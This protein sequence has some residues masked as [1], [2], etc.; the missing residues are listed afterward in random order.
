MRKLPRTPLFAIASFSNAI[1]SSVYSA[2]DKAKPIGEEKHDPIFEQ[3]HEWEL[4]E[5]RR[6]GKEFTRS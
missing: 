2:R 4:E 5:Q 3:L 6:R 1:I